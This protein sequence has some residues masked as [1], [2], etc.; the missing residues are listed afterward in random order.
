M[1]DKTSE[2][3]VSDWSMN[4]IMNLSLISSGKFIGRFVQGDILIGIA[5]LTGSALQKFVEKY[6]YRRK[7]FRM[8]PESNSLPLTI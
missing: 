5:N 4:R 7:K 8:V 1:R 2:A 6:L 3:Q